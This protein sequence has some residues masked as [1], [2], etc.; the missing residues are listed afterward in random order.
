MILMLRKLG[1]TSLQRFWKMGHMF[2]FLLTALFGVVRPPYRLDNLLKQIVF[3]GIHSLFV[4]VLTA[5]FAGM[6]LAL[7]G[8]YILSRFGSEGMVG[9]MVALAIVQ[10]LGPVLTALMVTGRAGSA[11]AGE[12]GVMRIKEQIDALESMGINPLKY[13]IAPRVEASL[14]TLPV[15]TAIFNVV[16]IFGGYLVAVQLLGMS[17]GTYWGG[18]ESKLAAKDIYISVIKSFSFGLIVAWVCTYMGYFTTRGAEGVGR[19]ITSAV[20]LTS[21]LVLIWDYFI[22]SV[23]L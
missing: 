9:P 2:L 6:V 7:Q 17:S 12:L 18:I 3:I 20:V 5:A 4:I 16:G 23:M 13:L 21:V 19:S 10:E 15:L 8:Y 22:T 11:M 1:R 14:I